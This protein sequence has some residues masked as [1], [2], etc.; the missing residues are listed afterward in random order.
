MNRTSFCGQLP[1]SSFTPPA[2]GDRE[3]QAAGGV[4]NMVELL[5]GLADRRRVDQRH[6]LRRIGHQHRV[7]Q[8]LVARLQIGQEQI[9]LQIVVQIRQLGVGAGDLQLDRA[10]ARRQQSLQPDALAAR[11]R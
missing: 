5:A 6:E 9:F 8:R 10:D 2:R 11:P 4:E 1:S 7:E 3:I